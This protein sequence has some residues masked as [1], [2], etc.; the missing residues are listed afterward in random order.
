[1]PE[2]F[3][4]I[5]VLGRGGFGKVTLVRHKGRGQ[6]YAMKTLKKSKV[7]EKDQVGRLNLAFLLAYTFMS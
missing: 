4:P 2:D 3:K 6:L 5:R 1:M 7:L